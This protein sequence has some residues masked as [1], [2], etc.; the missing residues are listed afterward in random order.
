MKLVIVG[1]G[2]FRVPQI[3]EVLA[4]ARRGRGASAGLIVDEVAL[5]DVSSKRL[6]VMR[7]VIDQLDLHSAP[8]VSIH[9]RLDTALCGAEFVF[10]AMRIGGTSGRVVDE[11]VALNEGVLGQET[12]GAGGYAYAFR[13]LPAALE[14]A[15][16]VRA[17]APDA[18]VINFTNPAGIITQAMREVLGKKVVGICDTPIGLVRRAATALDIEAHA[19]DHAD[20][21]VSFDYVGLNHLGWLRSFH[22]GAHDRLPELIGDDAKLDVIEEARIVGFD[23]IRA[24]KMLPSEYLFYYYLNRES[25]ERI[26]SDDVTRGQF[27]AQQQQK[28]YDDASS[29]PNRA[30]DL[31]RAAHR[32][33]EYT[34]MAESRDG[35]ERAGRRDADIAAGGY[36]R[37]ALDLMTALTHGEPARM[38][39]GV[40]NS[41]VQDGRGRLLPELSADAVIEVPCLVDRLGIHPIRVQPVRGPELGLMVSVKACEELVIRAVQTRS[42]DLAWQAIAAHPLIDS[43]R[44]AQRVLNGYMQKHPAIADV[45]QEK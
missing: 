25:V 43:I 8:Q 36:Q 42:I 21:N 26:R 10:S 4:G 34:Y 22:V 24:M 6:E 35:D 14:L 44:V 45:L 19:V 32:E 41:D 39:L 11:L 29:M 15:Y 37:V 28:F 23:W 16:A 31:W 20:P 9:T 3:I 1:G 7:S 38:I 18:W 2:G 40:G 12:V 30:A 27:L 33:R 17:H 13:T 5:Y